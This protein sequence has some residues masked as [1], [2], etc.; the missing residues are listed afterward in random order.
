MKPFIFIGDPHFSSRG[1]S[2]RLGD[3]VSDTFNK[4]DQIK[5]YALNNG[6]SLIV[7]SGD[8]LTTSDN[9]TEFI[10]SLISYFLDLKQLGVRV[11]SIV[12]NHDSSLTTLEN[13]KR[14]QA[15]T[16]FGS[17][18]IEKLDWDSEYRILGYSAYQDFSTL[19][20]FPEKDKVEYVVIHHFLCE[21]FG[22][23]LVA[24]PAVL[25]SIF[26]N[27]KAVLAGHDHQFY[28]SVIVNGVLTVR[29]GSLLRQNSNKMENNRVP[30]FSVISDTD[31]QFIP[32]QCQPFNII[33]PTEIKDSLKES[34]QELEKFLDKFNRNYSGSVGVESFVSD[35]FNKLDKS[36]PEFLSYLRQEIMD[37]GFSLI[38]E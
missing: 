17:N 6:I 27:L 28:G 37:A 10:N 24:Q 33:F 26:P 16:L 1:P 14:R 34:S 13:Y 22:D 23:K 19:E 9:S 8:I 12:G 4:L 11:V 30:C 20:S 21:T 18:C 25:K 35:V 15:G 3:Y 7:L 31:V 29:P 38:E 36:D 5:D 2:T 32:L